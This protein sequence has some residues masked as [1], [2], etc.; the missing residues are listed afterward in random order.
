M[1]EGDKRTLIIASQDTGLIEDINNADIE[2][3]FLEPGDQQYRIRESSTLTINPEQQ[4]TLITGT[5]IIVRLSEHA[6]SEYGIETKYK[7]TYWRMN[8]PSQAF[9]DAIENNL[10][11]K[12]EEYYNQ[13]APP[14][15]YFSSY[16]P[17]KE[18]SVPL[19]YK[20]KSPTVIGTTWKMGYN[21]RD[22]EHFKIIKLALS[23]GVGELNTTGFGFMNKMGR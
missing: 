14:R 13:Q 12:Y 17:R 1:N 3:T 23:A 18:V 5:P 16:Q 15:P 20:D 7:D 2:K 21:I 4:G 19:H 6:A 8:H 9:I 11:S 10:A 22:R